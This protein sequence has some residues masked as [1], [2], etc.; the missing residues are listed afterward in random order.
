MPL[1]HGVLGQETTGAGG[2]AMGI[3]SIPVLLDYVKMME[4]VCP[5][6]WLIN[7][8][9]PAGMLTEAVI[10]HTEWR[11]VVGICDAPTSM[12][13]VISAILGAKPDEVYLDYFGL[14]HLGW[15]KRIIY[16]N[17]DYLPD[18]LELAKSSGSVPGLP[19][20]SGLTHQPVDDPE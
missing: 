1:N 16:Q 17:R 12:H 8:A 14:N 18:M 7:F 20:D 15:I 19:F 6:A 5:N 3:R 9:N 4:Q 2:F 10:R 13:L 11:R